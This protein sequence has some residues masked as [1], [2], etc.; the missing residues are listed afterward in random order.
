ME[1][2]ISRVVIAVAEGRRNTAGL[3]EVDLQH[4]LQIQFCTTSESSANW[5]DTTNTISRLQPNVILITLNQQNS[6]L[7]K[8]LQSSLVDCEFRFIARKS[9]N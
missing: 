8:Q 6:L 2:E 1:K 4:P 7:T 9:F 3:V 5:H